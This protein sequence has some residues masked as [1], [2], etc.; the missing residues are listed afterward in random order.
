MST[1]TLLLPFVIAAGLCT[2]KAAMAPDSLVKRAAEAYAAGDHATAL[3]LFDSVALT[4]TSAALE[5]N[6]AHCHYRLGHIGPAVLH[7]ER[8]LLFAPGDE[9]IRAD[10]EL[11]RQR[12][13]DRMPTLPASPLRSLWDR[14]RGGQDPDQW[15]WRSILLV[16]GFFLL[17]SL[18]LFI[19]TRGPRLTAMV[20]AFLLLPFAL[21]AIVLA[22][23]RHGELTG[24]GAAIIMAPR[25][26]VLSEPRNGATKLYLLHEGTRVL[27]R[28]RNADWYEVRL[29]NGGVGWLAA[30]RLEPI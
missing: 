12:V 30:E 7:Y 11:A 10:L 6:I 14:L 21:G 24:R 18:S 17:L 25:V 16:L 26:D 9:A 2:V 13:L 5:Y 1:R 4:H 19:R 28:Q 27:L 15:A 22:R 8:A 29:D 20:A 3:A 23:V